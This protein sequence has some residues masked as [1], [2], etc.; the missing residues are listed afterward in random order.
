RLFR[1]AQTRHSGREESPHSPVADDRRTVLQPFEKAILGGHFVSFRTRSTH[2][3]GQARPGLAPCRGG[4][5]PKA[6]QGRFPRPSLDAERDAPVSTAD[7]TDPEN[8]R[9]AAA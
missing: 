9:G 4:R 8:A 6:S 1:A 7:L 5:L 3:S 2:P